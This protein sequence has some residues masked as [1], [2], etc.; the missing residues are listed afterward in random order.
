ME[1]SKVQNTYI[2]SMF[3]LFSLRPHAH[4]CKEQEK[5][6]SRERI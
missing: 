5:N 4:I 2:Y 6:I 1:D 3:Y